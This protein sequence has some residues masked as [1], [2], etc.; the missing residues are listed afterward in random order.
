MTLYICRKANRQSR[1][2]I[3]SVKVQFEK[4]LSL[5]IK[6]DKKSFFAY[7]RTKKKNAYSIGPLK[8]QD[9]DLTSDPERMAN[10]F[11]NKFVEVFCNEDL[12][13]MPQL[14]ANPSIINNLNNFTIN[15]TE[16]KEKLDKLREDKAAGP[17]ALKP[18]FLKMIAQRISYQAYSHL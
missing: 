13:A 6:S 8:A 18:R 1:N 3:H 2:A 17:D 14:P 15:E 11:N 10:I 12:S 7:V 9:N 5:K 4:K 16:V